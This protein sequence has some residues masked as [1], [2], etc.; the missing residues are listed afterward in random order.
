MSI[1]EKSKDIAYW[2]YRVVKQQIKSTVADKEQ[3]VIEE[4]F[5]ITEVYCDG[6]GHILF[7]I[8]NEDEKDPNSIKRMPPIGIDSVKDLRGCLN[9]MK[10]A[11]N[12]PILDYDELLKL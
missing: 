4:I 3:E 7:Y 1:V 12:K 6:D 11:L 9:L 10:R 5:F 8:T 2:E